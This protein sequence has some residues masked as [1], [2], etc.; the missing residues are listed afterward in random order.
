MRRAL[1]LFAVT[2]VLLGAGVA[3]AVTAGPSTPGS[4]GLRMNHLQAKGTHNSTHRDHNGDAVPGVPDWDYSHRP[5]TE[6]LEHQGVRQLELDLHY[7]WAK[8]DF[9]VYHVWFADD[10]TSCDTLTACL[11]EVRAWS[12]A[13]PAHHPILLMLE[14][15]DAQLEDEDPFTRPFDAHAYQ[16]LDEVIRAAWPDRVVTPDSVT[17]RGKTLRQSV[18]EMGWPKLDDVRG[19]VAFLIDGDDHGSAYSDGYRSL[20][21]RTAFVQAPETSAVAAFVGR[22]GG[23]AKYDRM[24]AL[25]AQGFMVRDLVGD[26]PRAALAA[27]A[28]YVSSDYPTDADYADAGMAPSRCNPVS[29]LA[30]GVD[31][32]NASIE[33]PAADGEPAPDPLPDEGQLLVDKA[34]RLVVGTV[35]SS[36]DA[37]VY[38]RLP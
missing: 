9:D 5:I 24:R 36:T 27:G 33:T 29:T 35:E 37:V 15:K 4:S 22:G 1:F 30:S 10:R 32:T 3:P 25:V 14:P 8:D 13:H 34:D 7:N 11:G 12:N 17:R 6:Q 23:G 16:R 21:G 18:V 26:D 2:C 28:H 31:C 19:H 38:E 20:A